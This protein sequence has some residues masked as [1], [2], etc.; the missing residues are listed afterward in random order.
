L[1]PLVTRAAQP[2]E[3][4]FG[5]GLMLCDVGTGDTAAL[6]VTAAAIWQAIAQPTAVSD[7]RRAL[8][9]QFAVD[10][11]TCAAAVESTLAELEARG[12]IRL[13]PGSGG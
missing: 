3:T 7:V 9:R 4:P 10:D 1:D 11:A 12:F 2:L 6:N 8:Q 13:T 5:D